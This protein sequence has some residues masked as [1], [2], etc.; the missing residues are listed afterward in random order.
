MTMM[1]LESSASYQLVVRQTF[2]LCNIFWIPDATPSVRV[3]L[4]EGHL[5]NVYHADQ[6][7]MLI[8]PETFKIEGDTWMLKLAFEGNLG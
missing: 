8:L 4:E 3:I 7:W 5:Q 2:C 6:D 1:T